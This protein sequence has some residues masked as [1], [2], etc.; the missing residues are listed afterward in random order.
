MTGMSLLV[1]GAVLFVG[2]HFLLSHGLRSRLVSA[3]GLK[4]Y[5]GVY[6]LLSL[7]SFAIMLWG[8]GK[9]DGAFL[10]S[11]PAW[12]Y[13][14]AQPVMLAAAILFVGSML[15]MSPA[16][17]ENDKALA[18][19]A[20]TRGVFA[21]TRHPMMWG[22]ALWAIVHM[23]MNGDSATLVLTSAILLL[24]LVGAAGQDVRKRAEIGPAW[25]GFVT[26]TSYWPFG[27]QISGRRDWSTLWPGWAAT[28]G[29]ILLY[30]ALLIG[31]DWLFG[32]PAFI[33]F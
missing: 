32:V 20:A 3:W 31:H 22:F 2:L 4:P 25:E 6:S 18:S 14:A 10:W 13:W 28:L 11:A 21:I 8:Y 30:G 7:I 23:V 15:N 5:L 12:G 1:I 16:A 29:G 27:A 9:A 26:R 33:S 17:P 19:P 24:A